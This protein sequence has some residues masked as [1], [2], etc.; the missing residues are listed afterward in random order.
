M[1]ASK[2]FENLKLIQIEKY[3]KSENDFERESIE[4][5]PKKI[6]YQAIE[7]CKPLLI[8]QRVRR[9]GVMYQVSGRVPALWQGISL[10][11][12]WHGI[13]IPG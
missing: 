1:F 13:S 4:L 7:N 3:H 2:T 10:P 6:L 9:G 12:E 5:D 11:G 8:T